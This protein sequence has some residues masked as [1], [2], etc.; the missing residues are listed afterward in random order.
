M[1]FA[2]EVRRLSLAGFTL[3]GTAT[4]FHRAPWGKRKH[5]APFPILSVVLLLTAM[6]S[7]TLLR[8]TVTLVDDSHITMTASVQNVVHPSGPTG[9]IVGIMTVTNHGANDIQITAA[10]GRIQSLARGTHDPDGRLDTTITIEVPLTIRAGQTVTVSFS[11]PFSGNVLSLQMDDSFRVS[12]SITWVGIPSSGPV[13]G[14][15]TYSQVKICSGPGPSPTN[16]YWVS[17][18]CTNA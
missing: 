2:A 6:A 17:T 1:G 4:R 14:P 16:P 8:M 11:G 5:L 10:S 9:K 12:P 18:S 3:P 15:F 7:P 13:E